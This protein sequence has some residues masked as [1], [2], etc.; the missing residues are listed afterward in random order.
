MVVVTYPS[1]KTIQ[2]IS[3]KHRFHTTRENYERRLIRE[4]AQLPLA[5]LSADGL[6]RPVLCIG[7]M[8]WGISWLIAECQ[9]LDTME[10]GEF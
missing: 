6:E 9:S 1:V 10:K 3:M 4:A 8:R 2:P 5:R 7:P